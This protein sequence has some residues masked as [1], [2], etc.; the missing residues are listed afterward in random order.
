MAT[1]FF[2]IAALLLYFAALVTIGIIFTPRTQSTQSFNLG[3]R[4]INYWVTA[5]ATQ[6][7]D[8]GSWLFLGLPA[9]IYQDG[10]PQ[11]WTAIGLVCGMWL[12]WHLIAPRL[13]VQTEKTA[14]S[15]LPAF[16]AHTFGGKG[17]NALRIL[18]ALLIMFF[19]TFYIASSLVGLSLIFHGAL[20]IPY[21]TGIIASMLTTALYTLIGGFAAVAWC[22]F[23]QGIFLLGMIILVPVATFFTLP[24]GIATIISAAQLNQIPLTLIESSYGTLNALLL[25]AGWGLGYFGQPHIL[26]NFMGIDDPKNIKYARRVGITWQILVLSSAIC[27]GLV[28]IGALSIPLENS[29]MVFVML[30]TKLFHP[31]IAGLVLCAVLAATLST[32]D[33][34]I[35][36]SGVSF[37]HDIAQVISPRSIN[38]KSLLACSRIGALLVS[39]IA[40]AIAWQNTQTVFD[41]VNYAWSG[42]GS[43]FGPLVIAALYFKKISAHTALFGMLAGSIVAALW[44]YGLPLVPGFFMG[45]LVLF[46]ASLV[47]NKR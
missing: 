21:H 10:L 42:L 36:A 20:G 18:G 34:L 6:A 46:I 14:S 12:T 11:A 2:F 47:K 41:L 29:Q 19:S 3:N 28:G 25:A 16:L 38:P 43:A 9:V 17:Q 13:R 23:F 33:S 35:L 39:A 27:V 40:L 31:F 22:D 44:P 24:D 15:T 8:M 30:T 5:I 32:V 45:L 1:P 4:S 37:A 26:M 7:S